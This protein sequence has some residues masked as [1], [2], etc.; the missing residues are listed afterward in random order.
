MAGEE[1]ERS[2]MEKMT[3]IEIMLWLVVSQLVSQ[4]ALAILHREGLSV[5]SSRGSSPVYCYVN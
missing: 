1:R 3:E 2:V 4:S 5:I